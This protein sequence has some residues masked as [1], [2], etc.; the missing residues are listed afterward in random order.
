MAK[1]KE[2]TGDEKERCAQVRLA[3]SNER[4]SCSEHTFQATAPAFIL[5]HMAK[6]YTHKH[7]NVNEWKTMQIDIIWTIC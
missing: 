5:L 7:M 1:Q 2:A 4:Y 6:Y 3:I